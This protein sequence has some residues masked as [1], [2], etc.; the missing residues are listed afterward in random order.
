M[1]N[2]YNHFVFRFLFIVLLLTQF[3]ASSPMMVVRRV[4]TPYYQT[5]QKLERMID[6]EQVLRRYR[7]SIP[8][9]Y[10][11]EFSVLTDVLDR[12]RRGQPIS[13]YTDEFSA[14]PFEFP[15]RSIK[16]KGKQ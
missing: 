16:Q 8:D 2:T 11:D 6:N 13:D 10:F 4:P 5:I 12:Q 9:G 15:L 3:I 1:S 7:K 14:D